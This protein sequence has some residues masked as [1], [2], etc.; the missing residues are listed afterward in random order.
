VKVLEPSS[1]ASR[2]AIR[3]RGRSLAWLLALLV[4]CLNPRPEELP[5]QTDTDG[6]GSSEQRPPGPDG[7]TGIGS[8]A[9]SV[10]TEAGGTNSDPANGPVDS[11]ELPDAGV[12]DDAGSDAA[13]PA[14][15]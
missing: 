13:P 1:G 6:P 7:V 12:P 4:G 11:P 14:Q 2:A 5:S 3:S 15:E 9:P 10:P 8:E